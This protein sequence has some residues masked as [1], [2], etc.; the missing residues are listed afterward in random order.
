MLPIVSGLL[1]MH[2]ARKYRPVHTWQV[3]NIGIKRDAVQI[4]DHQ[5]AFGQSFG[6]VLTVID[7]GFLVGARVESRLVEAE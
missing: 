5:Q 2:P 6:L 7:F 1:R 3:I 4:Y